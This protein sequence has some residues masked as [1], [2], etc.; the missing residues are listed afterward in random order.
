M[1]PTF[2]SKPSEFRKWLEKNHGK[3]TELWVGFYKKDSGKPSITW[4]ESVDEALCFGWIDGIRKS[5]DESSYVIRFTPRKPGSI[6][7]AVNIKKMSELEKKGLVYPA[8]KAAFAKRDAKKSEVYSFEQENVSLG[9]Y[10]KVFKKNKKAWS[11]FEAMAPSYKK[12]AIWWVVSAKQETTREKR[13][14]ALISDS[15][16]GLRIVHMRRPTDKK[17]GK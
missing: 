15:E 8:G 13:L 3:E 16:A 17:S 5:I 9:D 4:P 10:E 1:K 12:A 14:A 2:F 11:Q 6:W 7:S